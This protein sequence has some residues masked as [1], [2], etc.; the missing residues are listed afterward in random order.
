MVLG[1]PVL[2]LI[3]TVLVAVAEAGSDTTR[4]SLDRLE[5]ILEISQLDGQLPKG[6]NIGAALVVSTRPYYEESRGWFGTRAL[7]VLERSFGPGT[8]RLCEACMAPRAFVEDGHLVYQTGP[9]ALDEVQRLDEQTRGS[10][11]PART[12]IWLDEHRGGVGIRIV[13]L[14]N[15]QVLYAR[16]VDPTLNEVRNTQRSYTLAEE[17]ERRA[18]GLALTQAFVDFTIY[19]GQHLSLDWTDQW[20]KRNGALSGFTFSF[21]DPVVGV[22]A[23]HYQRI[24]LVN[25]L[26]GGK[27]ILSLPTAITRNISNDVGDIIDPVLTIVAVARVPFGRSNYGGILTASTNGEFGVGISLLNI[28]LIPVIP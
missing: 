8:L 4:D 20:G 13:D 11:V 18:K 16:N 14:R 21:Y 10:G 17:Y 25:A 5:E 7:E 12:A 19:P 2:T 9:I 15:G 26:V 6:D 22:G 27:V 1:S 24:P 28:S 23:S 3:A